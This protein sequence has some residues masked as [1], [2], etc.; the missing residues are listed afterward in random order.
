MKNYYKSNAKARGISW[1]LTNEQFLEL[2]T[3]DCDYCGHSQEYNGIDRIDSSKGYTIDN[4]V[5]C[6][7]WCNTMK[8]DY[9]KTEF[10]EHIKKIYNFQLEKQGSTTIEN[11]TDEVG[12]E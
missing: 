5:P 2:V 11:T 1:E 7:S 9:S 12:S 10:L 8:L 3:K 4:C 6:C